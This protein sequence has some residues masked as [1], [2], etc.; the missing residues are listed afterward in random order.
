MLRFLRCYSLHFIHYSELFRISLKF[1]V[2]LYF[3]YT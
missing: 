1:Q 2:D 3:V